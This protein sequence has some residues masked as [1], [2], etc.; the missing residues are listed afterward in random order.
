[1]ALGFGKTS[2][3]RTPQKVVN[4]AHEGRPA[5]RSPAKE[6]L[7]S[8]GTKLKAIRKEQK[9]SVPGSR[10][11]QGLLRKPSSSWKT[12]GGPSAFL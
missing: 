6:I 9:R 2:G 8:L 12:P 11:G 5:A 3:D 7:L 4:S 1:M 10:T